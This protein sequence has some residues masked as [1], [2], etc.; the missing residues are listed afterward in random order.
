MREQNI[1]VIETTRRQQDIIDVIREFTA[2]R[3]YPPS[4][5]EIGE[6]VGLSSSSTVQSHLRNLE[7]RGFLKRDPMRPR[8]LALAEDHGET[9]RIPLIGKISAGSPLL[10]V[11]NIEEE[12]SMSSL[13]VPDPGCFMLRVKGNSMVESGI[14]DKD[15]VVVKFTPEAEDGQIVIALINDEATIKRFY[16]SNGKI[17]L[18]PANR[19]MQAIWVTDVTII[20][21]VVAVI[22][23]IE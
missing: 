21:R 7:K 1:K 15:M 11:E 12:I 9:I 18:Q 17:H 14:L 5:R 19:D 6:R 23:R 10:S 16:R 2:E 4:V 22:R 20:G 8:T 3:G 13:I